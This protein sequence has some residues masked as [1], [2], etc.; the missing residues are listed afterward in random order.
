MYPGAGDEGAKC[1][2][3]AGGTCAHHDQIPLRTISNY[4]VDTALF[5]KYQNMDSADIY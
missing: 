3:E 5:K 2:K 1:G 4:H